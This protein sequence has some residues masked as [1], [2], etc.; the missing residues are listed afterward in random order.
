VILRGDQHTVCLAL[1]LPH[2]LE[3]A[4]GRVGERWA[5]KIPVRRHSPANSA[6]T[7]ACEEDV[8]LLAHD[9]V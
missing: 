2:L 5:S 3:R 8:E 1:A 4:T 6:R 9:G 7:K